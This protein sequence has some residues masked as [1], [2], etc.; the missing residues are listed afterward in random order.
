MIV[1]TGSTG[2][3]GGRVA[4]R[5]AAAGIPQR[6]LVRDPARAPLLDGAT[7]TT[8]EYSDATACR[9]ALTSGDTVLMVSAAEDADRLSQHRTFVDAAAEAGVGHLVYISFYGAGPASTFTLARDHWATEDHIKSTGL[10]HTFLRDNLYADFIPMMVGP[11]D[12]L[13]G[14]AGTGRASVVAQDDIADVATVV[15]RDPAPHTGLTHDLTG[16]AALTLTEMC[17]II[18]D[19]TGTPVRYHEETVTEAYESRSSH[20]APS[21]LVDA[22]VS[23]Y[24][25]IAAGEMNGVGSAIPDITGHPATPLAEVIR[26]NRS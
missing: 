11:D 13:R 3:L 1:V 20:Q 26:R 12:V 2:R 25:A 8:A 21:W 17:Q 24:T 7:V 15:L 14:P 9:N 5:L 23:T 18:T 10:P 4:R 22:W 16:P 19:V 6:L